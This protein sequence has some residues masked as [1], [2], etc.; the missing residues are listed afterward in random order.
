ML[1]GSALQESWPALV[2]AVLVV[3]L[4]VRRCR[5]EKAAGAAAARPEE[6]R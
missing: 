3:D 6:E 2:V 4:Q 5:L 1:L